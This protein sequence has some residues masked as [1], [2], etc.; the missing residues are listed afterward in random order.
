M[1]GTSE[2]IITDN[3]E[4]ITA[5]TLEEITADLSEEITEPPEETMSETSE[6]TFYEPRPREKKRM[7][8][9]EEERERDRNFHFT[10]HGH[11]KIRGR[12]GGKKRGKG[13]EIAMSFKKIKLLEDIIAVSFC[14]I[15]ITNI[16]ILYIKTLGFFVFLFVCLSELIEELASRRDTKIG[17]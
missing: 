17:M 8:R 5:E 4:E 7:E 10:S 12:R 16:R 13:A 11:V 3:P 2:E 15:I 1:T 14:A 9:R 6:E